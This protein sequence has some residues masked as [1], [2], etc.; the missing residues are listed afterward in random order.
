MKERYYSLDVFR[1]ATVALMILVNNPGNWGHIYP[2]LEHAAWHGITPTDLVFPFFLFAVGNAMAFVMPSL[3]SK[4]A[5]N[6]WKKIIKR[7][8]VIFC[9]GFLLNWI[10]FV[11]YDENNQLLF[12]PF[13]QV[14]IFGVLQRIALCYFFASIII[15]Y[16]KIRGAFVVS[17]FILLVYWYICIAGNP[18]DPFSLNGWFGTNIDKM[19][20]G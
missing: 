1:G 19:I 13:S 9:I 15:Y 3:R 7:T 16:L 6:F 10:P 14:R 4:G 11:H 18:A 5:G 20:I 8:V 17:A 2:P 12:Q